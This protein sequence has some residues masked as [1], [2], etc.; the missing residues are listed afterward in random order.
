MQAYEL[1]GINTE[2][3]YVFHDI[4][5]LETRQ[6]NHLDRSIPLIFKFSYLIIIEHFLCLFLIRSLHLYLL[7]SETFFL[8]VGIYFWWSI[9]VTPMSQFVRLNFGQVLSCDRL[10]T[11]QDLTRQQSSL[12]IIEGF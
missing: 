3:Q 4:Y 9:I 1:E 6:L 10:R 11:C 7:S 5:F 2:C 12:D 8:G